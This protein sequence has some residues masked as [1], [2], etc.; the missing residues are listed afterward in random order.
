VRELIDRYGSIEFATA[1]AQGIA[2]EAAS[3][4][5]DAF[6]AAQPGPDLEFVRALVPYMLGR[7]R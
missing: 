7:S 2:D 4:F 5:D 6:A 3:A 1:Y